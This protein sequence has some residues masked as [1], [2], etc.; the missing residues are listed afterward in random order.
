M[1]VQITTINAEG[2]PV[3]TE[4]GTPGKSEGEN[5]ESA[6]AGDKPEKTENPEDSESSEDA[7]GEDESQDA[8][9][10]DDDGN[11]SDDDKKPDD[12]KKRR[13]GF[14]RRVD[15]LNQRLSDQARET[16]FWKQKALEKE[17]PRGQSN[18]RVET[19]EKSNGKPKSDDFDSH[20]EFVEALAEWKLE[21]KLAD[22]DAK[23]RASQ[24]QTEYQ[25]ALS[26]HHAR[27]A[28][29]AKTKP[30]YEEVISDLGDFRVSAA[31]EHEI[32]S[33][34]NGPELLYELAKDPEEFERICSLPA[35]AAARA[36]GRLEE[37]IKSSSQKKETKIASSAPAPLSPVGSR[38]NSG[39][40]KSIRDA[41]LSFAEYEKLRMGKARASA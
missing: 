40:K 39:V 22:R 28:E 9:E 16:E 18:E 29:F 2:Q 6:A 33:S 20:E 5:R 10:S 38:S 19:T 31:V 7:G 21:Q 12:K 24:V 32:I 14:K 30:D 8:S 25:K 23:S 13:N 15:K 36:I 26:T 35:Q 34:E 3:T 11:E 4:V 1:S 27:T 41:D 17:S 37:R